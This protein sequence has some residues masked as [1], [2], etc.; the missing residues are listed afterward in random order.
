MTGLELFEIVTL[1]QRGDGERASCS[2]LLE[3]TLIL[4]AQVNE[5]DQRIAELD[6]FYRVEKREASRLRA[7]TGKLL[8]QWTSAKTALEAVDRLARGWESDPEFPVYLEFAKELRAALAA[9]PASTEVCGT[10][11]AHQRE[12]GWTCPRCGRVEPLAEQSNG[13]LCIGCGHPSG[14]FDAC[15]VCAQVREDAAY[16]N[17]DHRASLPLRVVENCGCVTWCV[18]DADG[19]PFAQTT[20][21]EAADFI[22]ERC[23]ASIGDAPSLRWTPAAEPPPDGEHVLV[24]SSARGELPDLA[25]Y[26]VATDRFDYAVGF[27]RRSGA[28]WWMPTRALTSLPN[29]SR[30]LEKP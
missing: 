27:V 26:D 8:Q 1:C 21:K 22:V 7:E 28:Q 20:W 19:K 15:L 9:A 6:E 13:D 2:Q 12:P 18:H 4:A 30:G 25:H 23:N 11:V 24:L 10:C 17:A 5:R 29:A 16:A 3:A 14:T